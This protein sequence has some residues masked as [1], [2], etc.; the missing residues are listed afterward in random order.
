MQIKLW[1]VRGSLP[2]PTTNSEYSK[3]IQKIVE[4]AIQA[5]LNG[6]SDVQEFI[7]ALP[8]D[9]K[10]VYGGNTTCVSVKSN[11]GKIYIIDCGSGMRLLGY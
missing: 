8:S 5:G 10:Y 11:S 2:S 6:T 3:K 9:L 1:G 7:E 4:L